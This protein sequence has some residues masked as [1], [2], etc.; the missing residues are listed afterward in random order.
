M[1]STK[2]IKSG[3]EDLKRITRADFYVCDGDGIQVC[4]TFEKLTIK[5]SSI[6]SFIQS[7]AE[8]QEINGHHFF[9]ITKSDDEKY[10]V[11]VNAHGGDGYM[12]GRIAVSEVMHFLGLGSERMDQD[13]FYQ[14]LLSSEMVPSEIDARARKLKIVNNILRAVYCI[15][16]DVDMTSTAREI[17]GNMY[18]DGSEDYVINIDE[19]V[20]ALIKRAN[21]EDELAEYALQIVSMLNT[22][23]MISAKVTYGKIKSNLMDLSESYKEAK[24]ALEVAKIFFEERDVASYSSLGIGRII[25]ELPKSLCETFLDEIF[26]GNEGKRL[27]DSEIMIINS[28]F[29]NSLSIADTSRELDIPRSTLIYRIEKIQKKTGLDIRVFEEAMTLKIALMVDK[30][31]KVLK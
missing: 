2:I 27:Q 23:L 15:E 24:M 29:D 17:L 9:K 11:I 1:A 16:M 22:E 26:G 7:S 25:H 13:E 14:E 3:L 21:S 18:T 28:F 10:I 20:I 12:I 30:Y 6:T 5:D 4:S 31:M 8:G 19:G